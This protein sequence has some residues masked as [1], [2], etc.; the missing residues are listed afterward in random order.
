MGFKVTNSA[1][2]RYNQCEREKQEK[3]QTSFKFMLALRK[4]LMPSISKDLLWK[5]WETITT[6]KNGKNMGVHCFARALVHMQSKLS[7][8]LGRKSITDAVKSWK[9]LNNIPDII[10]K[11]I[12]PHLSDNMTYN[13]IV[14]KPEQFEGAK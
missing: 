11:S 12:I 6:N 2:V 14:T 7:D 1:L 8:K 4:F 3:H 10:E 5:Q 9:L 13:D